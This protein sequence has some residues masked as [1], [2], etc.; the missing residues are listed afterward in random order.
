V[1][2]LVFRKLEEINVRPAV[3]AFYTA[4]DLWADDHTSGKM[5]AYHLNESIDVS[6]RNKDFIER[7]VG[8]IVKH[9]GVGESTSIIDFGCGP[10]LYAGLL[11]ECGAAVTGVDFSR[12]SLE[13][14]RK[15]ASE[16]GLRIKYV[17]QNYL[18]FDTDE[19]FDLAMM[20]MCDYCALSPEQRGAMAG[21]FYEL[22]RP[23]G[24]VLLDVYSLNA[25][26]QRAEAATYERN[27]LD[28]FWSSED[29]YAFLNTFKYDREKVV[30]DKYTIIEEARQKVVY[31]WLQYFSRESL[32]REFESHGFQI[33][34]FYCDVAGTAFDPE[35]DEFAIIAVKPLS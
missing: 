13:Y 8:W 19:R 11:A 25:F 31:N 26:R 3:F 4:A 29:Y 23:G 10:G 22:L 33:E 34:G 35:S 28:G 6:S 5:L 32:Q 15:V 27:Q 30:L 1:E 12:R 20:I 17:C 21:K 18:D 16:K 7:S 2:V 14:A 24:R 9:F